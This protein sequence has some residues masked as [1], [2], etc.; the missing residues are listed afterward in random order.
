MSKIIRKIPST[1]IQAIEQDRLPRDHIIYYDTEHGWVYQQRD[2]T[3]SSSIP[4]LIEE[5]TSTKLAED[6]F[7]LEKLGPFGKSSY[8]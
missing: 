2:E 4:K 7:P 3:L 5:S 1:I 8:F 6:V